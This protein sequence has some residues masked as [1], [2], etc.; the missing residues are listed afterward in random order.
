MDLDQLL[1]AIDQGALPPDVASDV[2]RVLQS[3]EPIQRPVTDSGGAIRLLRILPVRGAS[4]EPS[5]ALTLI[6][7]GAGRPRPPAVR[8]ELLA[9]LSHELRGPLS[10]LLHASTLLKQPSAS[11]ECREAAL[12]AIERQSKQLALLLDDLLD[13]SRLRQDQ[14]ELRRRR[15]DLRDTV[16]AAVAHV[17]P[18]AESA[19]VAIEV[20]LPGS[21]VPVLGDSDRLQQVLHNLLSNAI[22]YTRDGTRVRVSLTVDGDH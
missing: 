7:D 11:D 2:E 20:E 12:P 14:V 8:D 17:R 19:R 10:A 22:K 4:G 1:Y 15:I 5:V 13:I 6:D 16:S 21:E 9:T 18:S 3:R